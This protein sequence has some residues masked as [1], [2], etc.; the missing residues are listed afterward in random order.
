MR[1]G[2][3]FWIE[4]PEFFFIEDGDVTAVAGLPHKEKRHVDAWDA[5]SQCFFG[6]E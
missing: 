3:L 4:N 2:D 6:R 1:D 5:M